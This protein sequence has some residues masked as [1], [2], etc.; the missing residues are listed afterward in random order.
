MA[1]AYF[2]LGGPADDNQAYIDDAASA[3]KRGHCIC[4]LWQLNRRQQIEVNIS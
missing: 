1:I 4:N 2:S 3:M